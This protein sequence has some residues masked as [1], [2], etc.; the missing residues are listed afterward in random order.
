MS[1]TIPGR[2][3]VFHA[4]ELYPQGGIEDC[5]GFFSNLQTA[6][7]FLLASPFSRMKTKFVTADET[8][9]PLYWRDEWGYVYDMSNFCVVYGYTRGQRNLIIRMASTLLEEGPDAFREKYQRE[10]TPLE[11][12]LASTTLSEALNRQKQLQ[13][14]LQQKL[15]EQVKQQ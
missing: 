9:F 15:Q 14:D 12:L 4:L 10:P 11:S 8:G 7:D 13:Q 6:K 2:Y 3:A 1:Q 5:R